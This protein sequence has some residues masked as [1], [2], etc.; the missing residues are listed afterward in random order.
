LSFFSPPY[1][2]VEVSALIIVEAVLP[3]AVALA[4]TLPKA[5]C[6]SLKLSTFV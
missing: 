6:P 2:D 4:N 1:I 5:V 3:E